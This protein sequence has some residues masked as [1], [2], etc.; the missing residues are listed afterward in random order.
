MDYIEMPFSDSR[1]AKIAEWKAAGLVFLVGSFVSTFAPT[2]LPTGRATTKALWDKILT[3]SDQDFFGNELEELKDFPFEAIMHC[4]PDPVGIKR[5]IQGLFWENKP[6]EVHNCLANALASGSIEGLITTNYDLAFD[7]ALRSASNVITVFDDDG[8]T[9]YLNRRAAG[10][11]GTRPY[12]KIHGTAEP[13]EEETIVCNLNTERK[14]CRWKRELLA[15]IVRNRTLVVIGYSGSD[16]DI[17]PELAYAT[18]QE[19]TIWLQRGKHEIKP[20]AKR[21]LENRAG[22]VVIGDV[23]QFLECIL[24]K[25]CSPMPHEPTP[26]DLSD[27]DPSLIPEWRL[28]IL[29][30]VGCPKLLAECVDAIMRHNAEYRRAFY[31]QQGRYLD[32]IRALESEPS[33]SYRSDDDAF[34]HC[35]HVVIARLVYGQHLRPWLMLNRLSKSIARS[36]SVSV[37][38]Q[39]LAIEA[40]LVLYTRL[41]QFVRLFRIRPIVRFI[42]NKATPLYSDALEKLQD[43]G[44]WSRIQILQHN[45]E[46]MGIASAAG[47]PMP[48]QEGYANLGMLF[49]HAMTQRDSILGVRGLLTPERAQSVRSSL[50]KAEKYGWH[51]E[52]WKLSWILLWRESGQKWETLKKWTY[53][54]WRTQYAFPAR[55]MRLFLSLGPMK[56]GGLSV[57]K[58]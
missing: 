10:T 3:K 49:M 36:H 43:L 54:F 47:M 52:A 11:I 44:E 31:D 32:A 9:T 21:V 28:R 20:N 39:V 24:G 42:Q 34:L 58:P 41:T 5:I 33:E 35:L 1:T 25:K 17:C 55:L 37:N 22:T 13:G 51:N 26:I 46:R 19:R 53:H 40:R 12:F 48:S 6:N 2:N 14:L 7:T 23:S 29:N 50:D 4:Y 30:W 38:V 27:F 18:G 57:N 56:D 15:E 8:Y 45:G 16:F